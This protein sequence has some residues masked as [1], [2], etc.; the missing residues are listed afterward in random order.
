MRNMDIYGHP[1]SQGNNLLIEGF[2]ALV[3]CSTAS[4]LTFFYEGLFVS[5]TL[6]D[7]VG[8]EVGSLN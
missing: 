4:R 6:K 2:L 5:Y 1:V 8:C 3:F 7:T